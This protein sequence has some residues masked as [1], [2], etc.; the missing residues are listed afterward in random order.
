MVEKEKKRAKGLE[1][2]I[3]RKYLYKKS[4]KKTP[5]YLV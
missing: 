4:K 3:E 5:V 1:T 2:K